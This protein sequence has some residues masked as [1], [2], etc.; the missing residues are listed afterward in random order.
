MKKIF[1]LKNISFKIVSA[2]LLLLTLNACETFE[3]ELVDTPNALT[4]ASADPDLFLNSIQISTGSF[5]ES[6]TEEGMEVTRILHMFGPLYRNAYN[7]T[8]LNTPWST[9]YATIFADIET[10]LPLTDELGW[11]THSGI[12]KL[13]KS[14][15][16]LTLVDFLGD[17]PFENS[18]QGTADLEPSAVDDALVY[19]QILA[20][21]VEAREDLTVSPAPKAPA[22]DFFYGG[23]RSK[24]VKFANT[25]ELKLRIQRRLVA[26]PTDAAAIDALIAEGNL[27]TEKADDFQYRYST[28]QSNPDSRHPVFADNYNTSADVADYMSNSFMQEVTGKTVVDPRALYYFYRQTDDAED[29][30]ENEMPCSS[31]ARPSHYGPTDV[32]CYIGYLNSNV[33]SIGYWG[34]DHGDNDGIP[35][36][37][38]LRTAFGLYPVGGKFDDGSASS[39]TG[40]TDGLAGAGIS[41]IFLSSYTHFMIAEWEQS[42]GRDGR[43]LLEAGIRRSLDKVINFAADSGNAAAAAGAPDFTADVET[44]V[45]HVCGANNASS[46]WAT[47]TDKMDLIVREYFIALFGNGVE[48]YNTYRRTGKPANLQQTLNPVPGEFINSF[49]YPRNEVDNNGNL[50]Q[51]ATH[52]ESVFWA[53]GG[54]TVN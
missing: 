43:A 34:R 17:I 36:D 33:S 48:A 45:E 7:S 47:S 22:N 15:V 37:G 23:D 49:F 31:E 29:G 51:K 41:P 14:Y 53:V 13:L 21:I 28:T 44:Y 30:D 40:R 50:E 8:Q 10:M 52:H 3:L 18:A 2:C 38:G 25:L 9:A 12:A 27:I 5:F 4:G 24:W 1:N 35:P 32:F 11:N 46:L 54:P 19:D 39:V 42:Q 20:L 16:G 6:V 26:D